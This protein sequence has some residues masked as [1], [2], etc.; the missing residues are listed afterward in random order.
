MTDQKDQRSTP[1]GTP[2]DST[3]VTLGPIFLLLSMVQAIEEAGHGPAGISVTL[4]VRGIL[5]SGLLGTQE[6]YARD[7][8]ALFN[9]M[10]KNKL[11]REVL[12][13]VERGL[14]ARVTGAPTAWLHIRDAKFFQPGAAVGIPGAQLAN[15]WVRVR[16]DSVDAVMFGSLSPVGT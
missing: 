5:I 15:G 16:L 14:A 6:A 3:V 2:D 13:G 9:E 11:S 12:D 1:P 4:S 8:T 10:L 7:T